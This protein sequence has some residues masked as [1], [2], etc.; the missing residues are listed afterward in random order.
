MIRKKLIQ[1]A[2]RKTG[3]W[4]DLARCATFEVTSEEA[5]GPLENA[6]TSDAKKWIA[7]TP[8]EQI[9]RVR[10]D[11][12][13][14]ITKILLLFEET[15]S[16]AKPGI[17]P[18]LAA[19]RT[20]QPGSKLSVSS[21]ISAL[22]IPRR[23]ERLSSSPRKSEG[24]GAENYSGKKRRRTGITLTIRSE[25]S[26]FVSAPNRPSLEETLQSRQAIV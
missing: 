23:K 24:F 11:Q 17:C 14:K 18:L 5:C 19:G 8:G 6:L 3:K 7:C 1:E 10:F 21:S 4:L 15:D 2:E 13:Q 16:I 12:P 26:E 9:I 22:P 20:I 25:L